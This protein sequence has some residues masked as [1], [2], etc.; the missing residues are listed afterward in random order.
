MIYATVGKMPLG[1]DRLIKAADSLAASIGEKVFI[2]AGSSGYVPA[3]ASYKDFLTLPEAEAMQAEADV[4][5]SHA[6]IGTI[7]GALRSGTPIIIMPRREKLGEH[8][9]DHQMEIARAVLGRPGVEVVYD[10]AEL[11]AALG[12]L[13][14]QKGKFKPQEKGAGIIAAIEDFL[15]KNVR[16]T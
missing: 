9:N 5:I 15:E 7:I 13:L 8:F 2:Q 3:N 12:K 10:V 11:P 16:K 4:I 6:G 14:G 1:F